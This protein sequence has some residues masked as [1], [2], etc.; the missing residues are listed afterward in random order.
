VVEELLEEC[1]EDGVVHGGVLRGL[2]K[3]SKIR[4]TSGVFTGQLGEVSNFLQERE[5][6][7]QILLNLLGVPTRVT[8]PSYAIEAV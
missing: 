1:G 6:W 4:I 2:V 5:D 3:H 7:V 8:L